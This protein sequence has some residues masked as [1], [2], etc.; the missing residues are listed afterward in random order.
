MVGAM[1]SPRR[2]LATTVVPCALGAVVSLL[3]A[4]RTWR[5]AAG[6]GA[7]PLPKAELTGTQLLPWLPAVALVGLA[8]AGA[9]LAVRGRARSVLG[10]LLVVAGL[11]LVGA[12]IY[13][14]ATAGAAHLVFP[15]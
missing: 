15:F 5:V 10:L 4:A 8:G 7:L 11:P 14:T 13:G 2:E 6:Q 1:S 12:A 9:L 3:T